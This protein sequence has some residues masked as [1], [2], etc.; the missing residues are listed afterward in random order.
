MTCV[1]DGIIKSLTN[2]D[3]QKINLE[4]PVSAYTFMKAIKENN[5]HTVNVRVQNRAL[6]EKE[7]NENFQRINEINLNKLNN[8]YLC[9]S[10]EPLLNLVCQLFEVDINMNFNGSKI[11]YRNTLHSKR[12][13]EYSCSKTHFV[14][15]T[16]KVNTS[17][18]TNNNRSTYLP[19]N[20]SNSN[21]NTILYIIATLIIGLIL[22]AMFYQIKKK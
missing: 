13:L 14:S 19:D 20:S 12:V 17:Y 1:P 11:Q 3:F 16:S 15:T 9:S 6:S 7:L 4:N 18:T 10:H 5:T 22:L 2:E 21:S 8:G